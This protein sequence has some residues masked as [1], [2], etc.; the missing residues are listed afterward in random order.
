[1]K[2]LILLFTSLFILTTGVFAQANNTVDVTDDVY[3]LLRYAEIK[4][5]C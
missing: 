1:M 4:G 5:L 2:K 3:D